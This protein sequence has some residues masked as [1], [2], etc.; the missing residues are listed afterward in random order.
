M[1]TE[2]PNDP[3][4]ERAFLGSLFARPQ[5]VQKVSGLVM[6][7][8]FYKRA[9]QLIYA[10]MLRIAAS[11]ELPL[12]IVGVTRELLARKELDAAGGSINITNIASMS[13]DMPVALN[14][15]NNCKKYAEIILD[16]SRRRD[17]I[18]S[19]EEAVGLAVRGDDVANILQC[20]NDTLENVNRGT[21][22]NGI[23]ENLSAWETWCEE[24]R[25]LGECPGIPT[26]IYEL[27]G[28]TGGWQN[29]NLIILGA[30]PSMGKSALALNFAAA[31]CSEGHH[32]AIFSLEMTKRELISRLAAAEGDVDVTHTNIP[33]LLTDDEREK[34]KKVFENISKWGLYIDDTPGMPLSQIA[35]KSRRLKYAGKL[36]L[37]I[38]DHLNLIGTDTKKENRTNEVADI[39][40]RLK[41][42][43][44][45]L[46]V[47]V[48]CLCQLSR[49]V[50]SR[51]EKKPQM[52]D[53][54]ESG[55]IE[56]DADLVLLLYREGYYTKD[57]SDNSAELIISKH[58][59]GKTGT[60]NLIFT[61]EKQIF[62]DDVLQGVMTKA[63]EE[64]IPQ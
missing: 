39:T 58:R 36:D 19:F 60:V 25:L 48:I 7:R 14:D 15:F 3:Q 30:R 41:G 51:Q 37:V 26:G 45:E 55:T 33:A 13:I 18:K 20:L 35:T 40:K 8:D 28:M 6:P 54:R 12:D 56:Q 32:V 43:A 47:P 44:K 62:V 42:L 22:V 59:G 4:A 11:N 9:N 1:V 5:F 34:I 53:L 64:D 61:G 17:A 49:G 16:C 63:R 10:S 38:I 21:T 23:T 27:T 52:S 2:L 29:G 46:N 24:T 31:A 50:E 57:T